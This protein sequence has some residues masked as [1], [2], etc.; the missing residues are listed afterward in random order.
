M[1]PCECSVATGRWRGADEA[2]QYNQSQRV[3]RLKVLIVDFDGGPVG[4]SPLSS[5]CLGRQLTTWRTGA[6]LLEAVSTLDGSPSSPSFVVL[7]ANSSSA[8]LVQDRVF[9][10]KAWGAM[11][12]T[13]DASSRFEAAILDESL[14]GTYVAADAWVYTGLEVRYTT[15]RLSSSSWRVLP[16]ISSTQTWSAYVLPT[17]LRLQAVATQIFAQR[18]TIPRLLSLSG[19]TLSNAQARFIPAPV[20]ATFLNLTPFDFGSRV[21][22]NAF[23]T[24]MPILFVFFVRSLSVSSLSISLTSSPSS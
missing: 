18:T 13:A 1:A 20:S 10:G 19:A 5:L 22:Q 8:K 21:L 6:A 4:A 17:F 11:Y 14:A 2:L 9:E 3:S 12:A 16:L 23:G 7:P 15:V 24:V